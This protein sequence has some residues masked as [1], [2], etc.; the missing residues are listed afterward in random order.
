MGRSRNQSIEPDIDAALDYDQC[1]VERPY[2]HLWAT[3][4]HLAVR[5]YCDDLAKGGDGSSKIADWFWS[6][7]SEPRS[8]VWMCDL[9]NLDVDQTRKRVT[10][11]WKNL[12]SH[13]R[14]GT[15]GSE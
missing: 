10:A 8:F 6:N 15:K 11:N 4:L 5:D 12:S 13:N 7:S 14:G 2:R 3:V 1:I 9:F